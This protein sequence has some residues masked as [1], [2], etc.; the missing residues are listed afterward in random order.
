MDADDP[1]PEAILER[2]VTD[3]RD[4]LG[5]DLV[6]I[7]VYG[8]YVSGGFDPG[9][10]DLDLVAVVAPPVEAIDLAGLGRM[11]GDLVSRYPAWNERIEV[12]YVGQMALWSLPDEPRST[13]GHQPGRAVP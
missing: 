9:A 1:V 12:V 5:A 10:S 11:H 3:L 2:L 13:R 4:V 8:S 6:G 7:Y